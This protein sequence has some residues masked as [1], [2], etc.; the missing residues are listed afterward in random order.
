MTYTSIPLPNFNLTEIVEGQAEDFYLSYLQAPYMQLNSDVILREVD[1]I[2]NHQISKQDKIVTLSYLI[3]RLS[4][5]ILKLNERESINEWQT[6][7]HRLYRLIGQED[8]EIPNDP[9]SKESHAKAE[10]FITKINQTIQQLKADNP[11]EIESLNAIQEAVVKNS[12][13][14]GFGI[15]KWYEFVMGAIVGAAIQ[16]GALPLLLKKFPMLTELAKSLFK[17]YFLIK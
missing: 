3:N 8:I 13:F 7:L 14:L 12:K 17:G 11:D 1:S 4:E 15:E 2:Y 9:F 5:K 6:V 10:F 16:N